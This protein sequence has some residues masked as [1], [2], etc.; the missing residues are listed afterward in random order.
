MTENKKNPLEKDW[1]LTDEFYQENDEKKEVRLEDFLGGEEEEESNLNVSDDSQELK[2]TIAEVH[3]V[4]TMAGQGKTTEQIAALTGL[5]KQYVY[6]IQVCA[7]GFHEDDEIAV[8][9]LV[10]ME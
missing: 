7:Q 4:L 8:A 10:M 5:D 1:E 2:K 9:H 3:E 6:N